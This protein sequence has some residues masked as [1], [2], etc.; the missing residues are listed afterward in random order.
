MKSGLV[1]Q[2]SFYNMSN[3]S[4]K[5]VIVIA[6]PT[7][8]GKTG[9]AIE[10]A[11]KF[12]TE[13]ISADSRQVYREMKIGTAVPSEEELSQVKH[14]CIQHISIHEEYNVGAYE[15]EVLSILKGIF[16]Q[17]DIAILCGGTGLYINAVCDGLDEFPPIDLEIK[18]QVA[19]ICLDKEKA[20]ALLENLDPLY[21]NQVD[22]DNIRR[23]SRA[24]EVCLQ[25]KKAY[26]SFLTNNKKNRNFEIIK[27]CLSEDRNKLYDQINRRVDAMI[28]DGLVDECRALF[29]FKN[30]KSLQTVGYSELFDYFEG[31]TDL[32]FAIDKIKQHSR[33]YAKR[34]IT[35]F[36]KDDSY[37]FFKSSQLDEMID[38]MKKRM[39]D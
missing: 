33:N 38:F 1:V 12:Q 6:G 13:I 15:Q 8:V 10:L 39:H 22:R 31:K 5:Y 35:W 2:R 36:N 11:V 27:I 23:V 17:Q 29:P 37:T 28:G 3:P 34:Q 16:E 18:T 9:V 24:L 25:T 4:K 21:F 7:A 32:S 20:L 26:S 14:H 30:L 19:A